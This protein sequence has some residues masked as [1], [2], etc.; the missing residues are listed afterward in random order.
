MFERFTDQ[1]RSVIVRAQEQAAS[2]QH[3][4][5][6]TEHILLGL[7]AEQQGLAASALAS[8]DIRLDAVRDQVV[9]IIGRGNRPV[10]GHIPFTPRAKKVL[11]LSLRD[12]L[13]LGSNYID[14]EHILLGLLREGS[15]VAVV[16]LGNVAGDPQTVRRAVMALVHKGLPEGVTVARP[17]GV[18]AAIRPQQGILA[19]LRDIDAR[20]ANIEAHLGIRPLSQAAPGDP[21]LTEVPEESQP[22]PPPAGA[23][24]E[25]GAAGSE[26]GPGPE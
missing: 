1:A 22:A 20:L 16:I 2:L 8:L 13:Q 14:T 23:A 26:D 3:N 18:P 12:A 24:D 9:Q 17:A 25:T 19:T 6:G 10:S 5:I 15:G 11:E 7:I 21:E 4:Y